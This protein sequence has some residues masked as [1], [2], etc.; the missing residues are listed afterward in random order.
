ML[1]ESLIIAQVQIDVIA[2]LRTDAD[3]SHFQ[4]FVTEHFFDSR[5]TVG[6]FVGQFGL[7][8]RQDEVSARRSIPYGTYA[9]G[10]T[11]I[12]VLIGIGSHRSGNKLI[13]ILTE[14]G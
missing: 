13:V 10:G 3:V 9:A 2:V 12:V 11:H 14:Y 1:A 4:V 5:Q 7:Q 6:F 8:P